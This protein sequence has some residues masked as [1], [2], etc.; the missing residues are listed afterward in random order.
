LKSQ[1]PVLRTTRN[2]SS[3]G[4]ASLI[5]SDYVQRLKIPA[6]LDHLGAMSILR[7]IRILLSAQRA[8]IAS[9]VT[10]RLAQIDSIMRY[11][12]W[13]RNSVMLAAGN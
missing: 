10:R 5:L 13:A 4:Q 12:V 3:T 1:L 11:C 2:G 9:V 7:A 8:K 6:R